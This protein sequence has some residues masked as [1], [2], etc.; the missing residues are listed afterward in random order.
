MWDR[1]VSKQ[2]EINDLRNCFGGV[3]RPTIRSGHRKRP[4][5]DEVFLGRTGW[6]WAHTVINILI[7]FLY[8]FKRCGFWPINHALGAL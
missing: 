1:K 2:L 4:S 7:T 6:W 5:G 3:Q 8:Y